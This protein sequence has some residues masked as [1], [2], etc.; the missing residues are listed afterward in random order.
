MVGFKYLEYQP[1]LTTT[2]RSLYAEGLTR[3]KHLF[4]QKEKISIEEAVK[5]IADVRHHIV[6]REVHLSVLRDYE[7]TLEG[8]ATTV[9]SSM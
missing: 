7:A 8:N 4:F 6:L 2:Y 5:K 9:E 1:F 3:V